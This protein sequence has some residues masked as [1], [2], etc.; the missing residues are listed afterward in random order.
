MSIKSVN[1]TADL[2]MVHYMD[3]RVALDEKYH[4][5]SMKVTSQFST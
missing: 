2:L 1:S 3:G 4:T 5:T